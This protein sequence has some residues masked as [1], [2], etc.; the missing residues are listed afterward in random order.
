MEEIK[1]PF[2]KYQLRK[3]ELDKRVYLLR[4]KLIQTLNDTAIELIRQAA[5]PNINP[6]SPSPI[7]KLEVLKELQHK[8]KM[9]NEENRKLIDNQT[10]NLKEDEFGISFLEIE[11]N[12]LEAR[13]IDIN[14]KIKN[15]VKI[16]KE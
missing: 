15:L 4:E 5:N 12:E 8:V 13:F 10:K 16:V 11:D 9:F 1:R 14:S 3:D 2:T 6:F 7:A